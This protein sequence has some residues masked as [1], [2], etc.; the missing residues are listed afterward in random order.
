MNRMCAKGNLNCHTAWTR[1]VNPV[2]IEFNLLRAVAPLL[3]SS[4]GLL[5]GCSHPIPKNVQADQNI[6]YGR[7][8]GESLRLDTII[9]PLR[10]GQTCDTFHSE[11]RSV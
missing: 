7:A 6:E 4:L 10:N 3:L 8:S 5:A 11:V 1:K 9:F 2:K